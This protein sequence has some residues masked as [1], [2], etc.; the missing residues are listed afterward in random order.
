M[1]KYFILFLFLLFACNGNKKEQQHN[2]NDKS[3]YP[4]IAYESLLKSTELKKK[5]IDTLLYRYDSLSKKYDSLFKKNIVLQAKTDSLKTKLFLSN[6]K[7]EKVKFYLRIVERKPSQ[8]VFLR[9]WVT[10]AVK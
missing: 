6:Y 8:K 5:R 2:S 7:V 4:D 9:G 10:R 3:T 1:R